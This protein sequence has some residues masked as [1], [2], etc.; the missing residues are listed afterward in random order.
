[1]RYSRWFFPALVVS[2][3]LV[4]ACGGGGGGG[5]SGGTPP[6]TA[7]TSTPTVTPTLTPTLAPSPGA[8]QVPGA[9]FVTLTWSGPWSSALGASFGTAL[10]PVNF[11]GTGAGDAVTVTPTELQFSGGTFAA[12]LGS[13]AA[14]ATFSVTPATS[15]SAFTVTASA[16]GATCTLTVAGNI[17]T[18][19]A[20]LTLNA[21]ANI[22]GGAN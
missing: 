15:T 3:L 13:G 12:T 22:T 10:T 17:G 2:A 1:M 9:G 8:T 11:P 20:T 6:T 18:T 4:A 7:P 5:N 14:C 19:S 16:A 21:P